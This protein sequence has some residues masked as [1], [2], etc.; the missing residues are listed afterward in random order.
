M[1]GQRASA[2]PQSSPNP[3]SRIP[4][5]QSGFVVQQRLIHQHRQLSANC[6][7][8]REQLR[9]VDDHE[10]LAWIHLVGGP[11]C[12]AP[13]EGADRFDATVRAGSENDEEAE[14]ESE[15]RVRV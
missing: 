10:A 6:A 1:K 13:P 8:T 4:P 7:P 12:A 2:G 9:H 3:E 15:A 11:V 5:L 14:A